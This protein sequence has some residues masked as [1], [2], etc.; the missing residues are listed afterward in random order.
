[1]VYCFAVNCTNDSSKTK[2]KSYH[3]FPAAKSLK[4]QWL[5]KISRKD[6]NPTKESVVCSDHFTPDSYER[7]LQ[8][9]L[10]GYKPKPKLK[11]DAVPTLFS[12]SRPAKRPRLSSERRTQ[13]KEKNEV[14]PC[15]LYTVFGQ[16]SDK[17]PR[18]ELLIYLAP[19]SP[20]VIL[21][22][23]VPQKIFSLFFFLSYNPSWCVS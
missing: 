21:G 16:F 5:T 17:L 3:R 1:M 8:A 14:S 13:E 15:E 22:N 9:E 11:P 6:A 10:L 12:H 4:Q 23:Y 18:G 7:N 2:G 19:F 20:V